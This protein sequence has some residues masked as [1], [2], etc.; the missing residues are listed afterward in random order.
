MEFA[1][2]STHGPTVDLQIHKFLA[3]GPD[4]QGFLFIEMVWKEY[5]G[6]KFASGFSSGSCG[7]CS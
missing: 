3:W 7:Q 1:D 6:K 2:D 4:H 5:L